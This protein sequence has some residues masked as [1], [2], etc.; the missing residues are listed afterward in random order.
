[1]STEESM[2][3]VYIYETQ[4][5]LQNLDDILLDG[6]GV[7]QLDADQINEVF[8]VMHTIKG[9]SSMM[10]FEEI[11]KVAHAVED[12][13]AQIREN[14]A[15]DDQWPSVFD[16]VFRAVSF[17]N[18]ELAKIQ[19]S[20]K[21]DG[22]DEQ[23]IADLHRLLAQMKG[24]VPAASA[25]AAAA[26]VAAAPAEKAGEPAGG[27]PV[28]PFYKIKAR[29]EPDCKMEG[30]RALGV[31][32]ALK[33]ICPRVV[34]RPETL[35]GDAAA[36]AVAENGLT[37]YVQT[38]ENPDEL[39]H[40]L[41]TTLFLKK[42]S[43]LPIDGADEEIPE[44]IRLRGG[45]Q[46]EAPAGAPAAKAAP[47]AQKSEKTAPAA[48]MEGVAKQNFISV[49]VNKLDSLLNMVGEI[50][51]SQSMVIS[52]ANFGDRPH[53]NFDA[54]AKQ[55]HNLIN[56]LQDIVMSIR[57]L[58]VSTVF[59]KM[60]RL[61]RDMSK[62]V[63]KEV[64]LEMLGEETE[65]DKNVIDNLSDPLMH[66]IRNSVDHG[67]ETPEERVKLGKPE[68]G[69]VVLEARTTG[70]D[71]VVTVSDDGRGLQRGKILQKAREKGLLTK[72]EDEMTDREVY[73]LI[74]LPGFSTNET[75]TEYSG[76]GVGMDVVRKNIGQIGGSV[77]VES[78]AGRGTKMIIRIPLT[79]TIVD[80]MRFSVGNISFIVPTVS[81]K[82]AI[83]P[84]AG[85]IFTDPEGNEMIMLLGECYSVLR[86]S[87]L[88]QI[89][90]P[91]QKPEDG[92]LMHLT[93]EE[94]DF[95][96]LFDHLDGEYQVVAKTLPN[97]LSRCA[98]RLSG[99]SGCAVLG[100]GSINLIVDVNGLRANK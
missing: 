41:D 100:D 9:S 60:R 34:T 49:N 45:A 40:I 58:P 80:G 32:E 54:A 95:C 25:P 26:A 96:I 59:Q 23:L 29:F 84:K 19:A 44:T 17:F 73:S 53:D 77:S 67:I 42:Y 35:E 24:D 12:V 3:D 14:G 28:L 79:L 6:E 56:E 63:G 90:T 66:I 47:A 1:M 98:T 97:Y 18:G 50:V 30:I 38:A 81:V 92:M 85:D 71:V 89:D 75:V 43:V 87:K 94:Q 68:K 27:D 82:T 86:L 76:R 7:E 91:V 15:G 64:Q 13:F 46:G 31:R 5:L 88:F 16:M 51:T 21:P 83:K 61:V 8:R 33:K 78:E 72:A 65:V 69:R 11:A 39:N 55:L 37:V 93:T 20:G 2:L 48:V 22:A 62:K 74:F 4:Q 36:R 70:S 57:M 99:I 52:N 10:E